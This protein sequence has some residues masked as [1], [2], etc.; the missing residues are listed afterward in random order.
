[1]LRHDREMRDAELEG[2]RLLIHQ[3]RGGAFVGLDEGETETRAML[4][5]KRKARAAL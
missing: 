2:L 3:R 1:M 4:A 5:R